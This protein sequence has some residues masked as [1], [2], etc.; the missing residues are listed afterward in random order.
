MK[1]ARGYIRVRQKTI[2]D[3]RISNQN[4]QQNYGMGEDVTPNKRY[5]VSAFA[6]KISKF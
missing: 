3:K 6:D 4:L 2:G 1:K 5:I